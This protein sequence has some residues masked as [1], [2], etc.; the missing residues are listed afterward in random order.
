MSCRG[1]LKSGYG[2]DGDRRLGK[3]SEKLREFRLHLSNVA[4][5]IVEDLV[6]GGR[7]V[8]GIGFERSP[9]GGKVGET[10]SFFAIEV[11]SASMRSISRRPS[12]WISSGV[13][14]VVVRA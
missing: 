10:F 11:I 2:F 13:M 4:A 5:E 1:G 7:N 8:F 12:W 3:K 14:W 9:E 6:R